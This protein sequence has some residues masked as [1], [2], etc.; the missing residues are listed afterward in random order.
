MFSHLHVHTEFSLL[1]GLARVP[2]PHGTRPRARAGSDRPHRPRQP[3][4]R[5]RLLQ[6]G[7]RAGVKPIIG[8]EAYV[9]PDSRF[10]PRAEGQAL[11]P[12]DAALPE[13]D[14]LSQPADAGHEG[15]PGRLLLQAADGPASSCASTARGSSP[16]P[17][18]APASCTTCCSRGRYDEAVQAARWY[19]ETF[20]GY[21]LELQEHSMP[22]L[23][24]VNRQLVRDVAGDRHPARR[25]ERRPLRPS[26]RRRDPGHPALH[27]HQLVASW[28][29]SASAC[30]T[31]PTT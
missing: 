19:Q 6:G 1:D 12:P 27:R 18:A 30:P 9:A 11:A 14:R 16:S 17:A 20:D 25:H 10:E 28:T 21:Y 5:H 31:T 8:V 23:T 7:P 4:R 24:E 22:E 2:R 15:E 3:L 13:H 29:R 26:V